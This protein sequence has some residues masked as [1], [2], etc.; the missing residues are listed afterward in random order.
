MED[1][2]EELLAP[3]TQT[4]RWLVPAGAG[5]VALAVVV[6][7]VVKQS[8]HRQA[9][10]PAV[11][12]PTPAGPAGLG[13]R[14]VH[15]LAIDQQGQLY[16][17]ASEPDELVAVARDGSV[18]GRLI[19]P[20]AAKFVI[21]SPTADRIWVI[22][23]RDD[24]S[25][26]FVYRASTTETITNY[27]V[28]ASVAAAAALGDQLWTATDHGI[29]R[30]AT[31]LPGFTGSAQVL[32]ADPARARLLAV[33]ASYDLIVVD[34]GRPRVVRRLTE[35]LPESIAVTDNA[36]WVVGFGRPSGQRLGRLDPRTLQVTL[37]GPP[38]PNAP[39]GAT[40]QAGRETVWIS[41]AY[42]SSVVCVDARTGRPVATFANAAGRVVS[43][44]GTAY[45]VYSGAVVRLPTT[46]ACPG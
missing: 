20:T 32:A 21:A 3:R 4:P 2:D 22:A 38:D 5:L 24:H 31:R 23:P 41:Y 44:P 1:G 10:A 35:I 17:L 28:P 16:A 29:F 27:Q 13:G 18:R 9:A 42:S 40:A 34:S 46:E 37:V 8:G 12:S 39:Q 36:V 43:V 14:F 11:P 30:E 19:A 33:S 25:D 45:T 15:D 6:G 7:L 26:V